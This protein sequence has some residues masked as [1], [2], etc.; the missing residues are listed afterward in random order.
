VAL[1]EKKGA[2]ARS[3][4][5]IQTYPA[6]MSSWAGKPRAPWPGNG[7]VQA[8]PPETRCLFKDDLHSR[9]WSI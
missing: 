6:P 5:G 2:Y 4:S 7:T 3:S 9:V 1:R 8:S